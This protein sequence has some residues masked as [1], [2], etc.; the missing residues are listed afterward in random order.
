MGEGH[1]RRPYNRKS[2]T[3]ESSRTTASSSPSPDKPKEY[4]SV[5]QR[6]TAFDKHITELHEKIFRSI[7]SN[8]YIC[9]L[10]PCSTIAH[11][12]WDCTARFTAHTPRE[13]QMFLDHLKRDHA[14]SPEALRWYH[15]TCCPKDT[16]SYTDPRIR[17]TAES[18]SL[19]F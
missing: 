5:F 10:C 14:Q 17:K 12:N 11:G 1:E 15:H 4:A 9:A 2:D 19:S 7:N 6:P 3:D 16:A 18:F 13:R 8:E